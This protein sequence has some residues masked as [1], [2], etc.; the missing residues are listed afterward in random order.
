LSK[1]IE[2]PTSYKI[3]QL[4]YPGRTGVTQGLFV[5]NGKLKIGVCDLRGDELPMGY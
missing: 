4:S 3:Q 1:E 2:R 5:S